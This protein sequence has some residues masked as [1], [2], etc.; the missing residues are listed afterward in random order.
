MF[1]KVLRVEADSG[2]LPF[3]KLHIPPLV[4]IMQY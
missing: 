1:K 3:Y 2:S 4:R